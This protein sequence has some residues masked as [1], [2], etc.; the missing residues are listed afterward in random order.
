MYGY[1]C[2]ILCGKCFESEQCHHVNGTCMNGCDSGYQGEHCTEGNSV[3]FFLGKYYF[4]LQLRITKKIFC[5]F[6]VECQDN[7]FG[8]NCEHICNV[9]CKS[10]NK[11]TGVCDNGCYPGWT[12]QYCQNGN[13]LFITEDV[14]LKPILWRSVQWPLWTLPLSDNMSPC[15]WSLLI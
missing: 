2:S 12:G 8:R 5:H 10:C 15:Y 3:G 7:F 4:F 11:T 13:N 9:T 6:L 1:N 14:F